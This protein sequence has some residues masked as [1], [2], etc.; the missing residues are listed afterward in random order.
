MEPLILASNSSRRKQLL[1]LLQIP[2]E[3]VPSRVREELVQAPQPQQ[4]ALELAALKAREVANDYPAR[5]VVGADTVVWLDGKALGK[6]TGHED[7]RRMLELLQGRVHTVVTGL[8]VV[9]LDKGLQKNCAVSTLV[10]MR[11]LSDKELDWYVST[12][13]PMDKAGAYGIQGLGSMFITRIQGSY[14]NVVGLPI[15]ELVRILRELG[16][17]DFLLLPR[18]T[19][20]Q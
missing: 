1:E 19:R 6:P 16:A 3:A 2:F 10:E 5:W 7:A 18:G 14:T 4:L 11:G 9:R 12:G 17:W 13:E 15:P 20:C 8:C